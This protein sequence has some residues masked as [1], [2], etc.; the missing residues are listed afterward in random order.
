MFSEIL[1]RTTSTYVHNTIQYLHLKKLCQFILVLI[2]NQIRASLFRSS[3]QQNKIIYSLSLWLL[4]KNACTNR[5]WKLLFQILQRT[6]KTSLKITI[7]DVNTITETAQKKTS[8][9]NLTLFHFSALMWILQ[10]FFWLNIWNFDLW[11]CI[12]VMKAVSSLHY[13]NVS[14]SSLCDGDTSFKWMTVSGIYKTCSQLTIE[15]SLLL[16]S[17]YQFYLT[18]P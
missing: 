5:T 6:R 17:N 3:I 13:I 14:L 9:S 12:D 11:C 18:W 1:L 8:A 4:N 2:N 10:F 7:I 16:F 15:F